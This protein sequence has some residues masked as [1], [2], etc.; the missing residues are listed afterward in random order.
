MISSLLL[1]DYSSKIVDN[2]PSIFFNISVH[3]P[4]Q[5]LNRTFYS[6]FICGCLHDP[7]SGL[8]FSLSHTQPWE[9]I[10]EV[11]YSETCGIDVKENYNQ[12]LPILSIISSSTLK[13]VT[14]E[15]YQLSIDKE[16]EI[17]A[18][19]L[20]AFEDET[21]DC[22]AITEINGKEKPVSFEQITNINECREH[23]YNCI[24]K[25]ASNLP[26][27]KIYELSFIKF[28]YRRIRFFQG[29]YYCWNQ[30]IQRLGSIA[31]KQMI[32]EA[33]SLTQISYKNHN[34]PHV[35]LVYDPGFSLHL[36]HA[37]WNHVS[38]DLKS[39]F[40][41]RDPFLSEDYQNKDYFAECLAWL[42]DIKYE[43]FV[44]VADEMKFILTENFAYKLFHIHERKLTRLA[45]IIEGETGVGKTFLLKFY[46]LLLNTKSTIDCRR[47]NIT[48]K[49]KENSNKFLLNVIVTVLENQENILNEFL[50]KIKPNILHIDDDDDED[51]D[52]LLNQQTRPLQVL[53]VVEQQIQNNEPID[54]VLLRNIKEY[55]KNAQLKKSILY[56]I[57]KAILN[58]ATEYGTTS[59]TN[60]IQSLH[61]HIANELVTYPL[62]ASSSRLQDL[63]EENDL[64]TA[65][66]SIELF[67]EYLFHSQIK[68]LFYRLLMHPSI[69]EER[70]VEFM[71]PI[72]QLARNLPK[73]EIVVFFDEI[74]TASC[75]GLFK[76]M[77]MDGT[78]YGT[79]LPKNIFF[80]AAINPWKKNETSIEQ[81]HRNDYIVHDL[82]QSLKDL[83]VSYGVLESKTLSDYIIRK[84][85]MF[86]VTS[87]AQNDETMPL[88][89]Y[90]QNTL[91]RSILNA[92]A[93]CE[94]HLGNSI[95]KFRR[96]FIFCMYL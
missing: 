51:E 11:P 60:L 18:R 36:L 86:Q 42:I 19:F 32:E 79:S 96:L 70:L 67:K 92:Q 25:Y 21:I 41:Y 69:T 85:R 35:Y 24:Q 29:S 39:L 74:N 34:Y 10:I 1:F 54:D 75:L 65:E 16:E 80:T 4:F 9:F 33:K 62:I 81:V 30:N 84:I 40:N 28:L 83:T 66:K 7:T 3:A 64:Q 53:P 31:M 78:L 72:C 13:E 15:N 27:N 56:H 47:E 8:I 95:N 88:E 55:L 77:F 22:M 87:S 82:P 71:S 44:K 26:R 68:S 6:L 91:T 50:R 89:E 5:S 17:V 49:I 46:S 52:E 43:T 73:I 76:E 37:D 23:I 58:V 63:L 38:N 12:I 61:D 57:W 20:K 59:I 48:S 90:A 14:D 94:E 45:L 93:F 2:S